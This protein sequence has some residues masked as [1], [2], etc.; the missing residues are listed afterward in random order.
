VS[1]LP[2]LFNHVRAQLDPPDGMIVETV[3]VRGDPAASLLLFAQQ[4]QGD[5]IAVGTPR[6]SFLERLVV[7]SVRCAGGDVGPTRGARVG[8]QC[9][10]F[11]V[12]CVPGHGQPNQR[13]TPAAAASASKSTPARAKPWTTD[14]DDVAG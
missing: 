6:H 3:I 9:L 14:A 4:T 8:L 10:R 12:L 5:L 2:P 7:G 11:R 13:L 1:R